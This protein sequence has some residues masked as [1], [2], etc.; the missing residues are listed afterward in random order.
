[1]TNA[2]QCR[3]K[4][5]PFE[6]KFGLRYGCNMGKYFLKVNGWKLYY[7]RMKCRVICSI[8]KAYSRKYNRGKRTENYV[9][10]EGAGG[11]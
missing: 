2:I 4:H 3:K 11:N 8:S 1:M 7:L 5:R 10:K 6:I 9:I